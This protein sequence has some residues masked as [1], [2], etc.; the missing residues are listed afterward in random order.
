MQSKESRED[1]PATD[2]QLEKIA[3]FLHKEVK[4]LTRREVED[5]GGQASEEEQQHPAS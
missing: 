1:L 4:D 2:D 5:V 3:D